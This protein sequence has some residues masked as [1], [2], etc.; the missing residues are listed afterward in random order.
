[1]KAIANDMKCTERTIVVQRRRQ[2]SAVRFKQDNCAQKLAERRLA[3][4]KLMLVNITE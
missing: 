2:V 3:V 4:V 1:M